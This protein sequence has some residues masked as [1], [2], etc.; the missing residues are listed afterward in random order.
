MAT[1]HSDDT[2]KSN[3]LLKELDEGEI[4]EADA[5]DKDTK[6]FIQEYAKQYQEEL[7]EDGKLTPQFEKKLNGMSKAEVVDYF[8][9][10]RHKFQH[11]S[12][13]E[14]DGTEAAHQYRREFA[15]GAIRERIGELTKIDI[16]NLLRA[17][18]RGTRIT[19]ASSSSSTKAA[20]SAGNA[21]DT[22]NENAMLNH[23]N[24]GLQMNKEGAGHAVKMAK[25]VGKL[26]SSEEIMPHQADILFDYLGK[27]Q[28]KGQSIL[29]LYR[30]T[31]HYAKLTPLAKGQFAGTYNYYV[32]EL[33]R[34]MADARKGVNK[35]GVVVRRSFVVNTCPL[36]TRTPA[37]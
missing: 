32:D 19:Q 21:K 14:K 30:E 10:H 17:V 15:I 36:A 22:R 31:D 13:S 7:R 11:K 26:L 27:H 25:F 35:D 20:N 18:D 37:K 9:H 8:Q 6:E 2:Q 33:T 5:D 29:A 16:Y 3:E 23:L 1:E 28:Y 34:V 4:A 24:K 12:G